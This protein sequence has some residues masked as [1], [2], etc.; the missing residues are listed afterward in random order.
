[1]PGVPG[2]IR[3]IVGRIN[4]RKTVSRRIFE[5]NGPAN[6]TL[7]VNEPFVGCVVFDIPRFSE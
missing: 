2:L 7:P 5:E 4:L 6:F 1:M 3:I